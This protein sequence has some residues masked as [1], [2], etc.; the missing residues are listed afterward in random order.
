MGIDPRKLD[1]LR[2]VSAEIL[3]SWVAGQ[4]PESQY[5]QA[6]KSELER[7]ERRTKW[8]MW[9]IGIGVAALGVIMAVLK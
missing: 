6:A 3:N 9:S 1:D 4:K 5:Y 2:N 7:R 8:I